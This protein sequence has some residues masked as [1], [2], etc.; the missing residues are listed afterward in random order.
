[1]VSKRHTSPLFQNFIYILFRVSIKKGL[2]ISSKPISHLVWLVLLRQL[3]SL[4]FKRRHIFT[5][6]TRNDVLI[7][8]VDIQFTRSLGPFSL[9][10]ISCHSLS[11]PEASLYKKK[12]TR[13]WELRFFPSIGSSFYS[14]KLF[15]VN[16]TSFVAKVR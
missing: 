7:K 16:F 6:T 1:M 3:P 8:R 11:S 2:E 12:P 14:H 4:F 15:V 13:V 9:F 5:L 10:Q